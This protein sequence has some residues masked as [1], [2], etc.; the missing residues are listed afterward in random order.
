MSI[1]LVKALVA[2]VAARIRPEV[3][4]KTRVKTIARYA[5]SGIINDKEN[6]STN[7]QVLEVIF[8]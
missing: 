1:V 3:A 4:Q 2:V 7:L 8:L 6:P 5:V